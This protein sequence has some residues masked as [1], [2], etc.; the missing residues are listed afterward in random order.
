MF[1]I[2]TDAGKFWAGYDGTWFGSGNPAAGTNDSGQDISLY[3]T[4]FP[5]ISRIGS[6]GS[7]AFIFNFGQTSF[8]HTP[9][10][11]FSKLNQDNLDDTSSKNTAWAWIKNRDATDS[12]ML[13]DRVRG[14]GVEVHTDGTTTTPETTNT[15]TVQRFLQRG[16][17]IGSDVQVNTANE[18]YVLWQWLVGDS[19][20]T[21]S[22]IGAGSISTGVPSLASTALAADAGHFSVVSWTGNET[23]GATIGHGL[24]GT[25]E[26][27]IAIARAESGENKPVYHKFMTADTD[28]LKI[29]EGNG[30]GT[31]GTTI[32]DVS[33]MS[34]TLIGLGAAVQSNSNNGMIAYCFRSV[35]GVCKVGSYIG[36]G[37]GSGTI[38]GPYINCG[39]RPRWIMFK[40]VSGG[41][42]SGEGWV[43][44]DTARQ[45]I[46]P[47]DD[48]DLIPNTTA[49]E[50][51]GATHGADI[52][53][54]G[55]KLRG[56]G[57]AVNKSGATY[58]YVAMADLG[59]NGTLPPIYGR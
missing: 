50:A 31:A 54:D 29:N 48:A 8:A 23:A 35:P 58:L 7:G 13:I 39:F 26:F 5:A 34:S 9:P 6:A 10:T 55:F 47:N 40:W 57:G 59:G 36:N 41:S 33:A 16:V 38:S 19:A 18:S 22:S 12:H 2:D 4:W 14:V 17:Q 43:V 3:D 46:N 42:L 24:G 21:G 45:I 20:T 52:L 32:W 30:Q 28:H 25:P 37:S 15:N 27:I 11:G 44:K 49:A 53:S 1:A 56:G 51:A